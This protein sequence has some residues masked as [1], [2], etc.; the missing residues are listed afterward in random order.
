M[1][2]SE[3][4]NWKSQRR[5]KV[6]HFS[7]WN[8]WFEC[9]FSMDSTWGWNLISAEGLK[10]TPFMFSVEYVEWRGIESPYATMPRNKDVNIWGKTRVQQNSNA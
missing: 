10:S 9:C 6:A 3:K 1:L 8:S 4:N 7:T 5:L 2:P